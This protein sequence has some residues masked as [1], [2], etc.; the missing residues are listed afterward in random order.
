MTMMKSTLYYN[1]VILTQ[2]RTLPVATAM[3][4][5]GNYIAAV[6]SDDEVKQAVHPETIRVDLQGRCVMPGFNDAHVHVWKV[7]QLESFVIDLRGIGS[8]SELIDKLKVSAAK[9][10][11]GTWITGRGFN[12]QVLA[13]KRMPEKEDL[14]AIST[15]HPIYLIRTC[16]HIGVV[17]TLALQYAGINENTTATPGGV[18]GRQSNGEPTGI[19]YETALGLITNH[20]PPPTTAEYKQMILIGARRLLEVGVTSATDP[21]VHPELLQAYYEVYHEKSSPVRFNLM[22]ILL[23]DGGNKPYPIPEK[24]DSDSL[25]VQ[26][27]KFFSD[28]GLSGKTAALTRAYKNSTDRGVLRLQRNVFFALANEAQQKGFRIGTHAI[29]DEA[30]AL[31]IDVYK[32]LYELYGDTRNRIEHL[33]LPTAQ[34]I[35]DLAKYRFVCVPQPIF[36]AELGENFIHA[37]DEYYLNQCYPAKSLLAKD[38][39]LA[40]STD[41]PVVKDINP[42]RGIKAAVTRSTSAGNF[43]AAHEAVSVEDALFAYTMGS[44]YAEQKEMVKG[45]IEKGKLADFIILNQNPLA[46]AA[47]EIETVHVLATYVNGICV[48]ERNILNEQ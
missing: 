13:E 33:G 44:A 25:S 36:L 46:V 37:L 38:I 9:L 47:A 29:G 8:I 21:A 28:G 39:P 26:T 34:H 10:P 27:V 3:V 20:I 4:V 41:A 2:Q 22:P 35:D 42:W 1:G 32:S 40:Y 45:S 5:E 11:A 18:I 19:F 14:D 24:F 30:I 48:Y 31:V 17:N 6:G 16:A 23:P 43:I 12:E 7:G 15:Q